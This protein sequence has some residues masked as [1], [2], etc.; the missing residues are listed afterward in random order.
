MFRPFPAV[1]FNLKA[2]NLRRLWRQKKLYPRILQFYCFQ[3]RDPVTSTETSPAPQHP[4]SVSPEGGGV[5]ARGGE[6]AT[7]HLFHPRQSQSWAQTNPSVLPPSPPTASLKNWLSGPRG[8]GGLRE[9]HFQT[10]CFSERVRK[11]AEAAVGSW[12]GG[13][14]ELSLSLC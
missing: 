9:K 4:L 14:V 3:L 12:P 6:I 10:N 5:E 11:K 7:C 13:R 2:A 8:G 1:N